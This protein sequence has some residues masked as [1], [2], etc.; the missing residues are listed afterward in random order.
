MLN[1]L[2]IN[3]VALLTNNPNQ[4]KQL[5]EH[6]IVVSETV[7]LVA[8]VGQDNLQYLQTKVERMGAPSALRSWNEWGRGRELNPGWQNRNLPC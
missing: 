8:G 3:E 4:V 5:E 7:P 6:G 2:G 1:D